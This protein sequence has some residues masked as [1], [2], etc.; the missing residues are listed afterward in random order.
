V[1]EAP[2]VDAVAE[3]LNRLETARFVRQSESGWKLYDFEELRVAAA[4][5]PGLEKAAG[6]VNPRLPGWHNDLIQL[7][8]KLPAC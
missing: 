2:P 4:A 8:K 6:M 3:I 1:V 7:G 5:L